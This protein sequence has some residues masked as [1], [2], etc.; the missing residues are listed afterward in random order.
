MQNINVIL[1]CNNFLQHYFL[2]VKNKLRRP[3][4]DERVFGEKH[5]E[6]FEDLKDLIEFTKNYPKEKTKL[7]LISPIPSPATNEKCKDVFKLVCDGMKRLSQENSEW[8]KFLN[9]TQKFMPNGLGQI[10]LSLFT[11]DQ[12]HLSLDGTNLLAK[13]IRAKLVRDCPKPK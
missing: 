6:F 10:D 11:P 1:N 4:E 9:V 2:K 8:V 5:D 7:L 12:I 3:S 13:E